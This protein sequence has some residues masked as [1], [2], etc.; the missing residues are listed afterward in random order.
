MRRVLKLARRT[1][2]AYD[3]RRAAR[4]EVEHIRAVTE[5]IIRQL[6]SDGRRPLPQGALSKAD[7]YARDVL[8]SLVYAAWLR[9]YTVLAGEF[10][11]G[12]IPDNY[13]TKVVIPQIDYKYRLGSSRKTFIRRVLRSPNIP[14]CAYLLR[15][16]F[17]D[18]NFQ[19]I[20][21]G[22]LADVLFD[23]ADTLVFKP[24]NSERGAQVEI[25]TRATLDVDKCRQAKDGVFQSYVAQH[26]FFDEMT[27]GSAT[28]LR[29]TTALDQ[30]G[31]VTVRA[32]YLRIARQ[33]DG[34]V[35][36]DSAIK[37]PVDL[38]AGTLV[39][40]G[41]MPNWAKVD[42]HPDSGFVFAGRTIPDFRGA[43]AL[44]AD[45]H[46]SFPHLSCIGWDICI[47][48]EGV[49]RILEW[50]TYYNDIKFSEAT[51]GPCFADMG[52]EQLWRS[53]LQGAS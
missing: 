42:R 48:V 4:G 20:D 30:A 37:V 3:A 12:W 17:Y 41:Y 13:Y 49:A 34:H 18:R 45:L 25:V 38:A 5:P 9:V 22:D 6:Q 47:D 32:A 19:R 21:E 7:E 39:D 44:V 11:V 23:E 43:T 24:D 31:E 46:R 50:N 53:P 26:P 2:N 52:W 16:L 40:T 33:S 10:R 1:L 27:T 29:L 36:S 14:D 15:R 28:T 8:G 51:T 35:R